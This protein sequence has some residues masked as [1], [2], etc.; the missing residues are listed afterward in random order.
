METKIQLLNANDIDKLNELVSI[1]ERVFEMENFKRPTRKHFEQVLYQDNFIA[2]IAMIDGRVVGGLTLYILHQYYS[3]KPL[4]YL[5]D[6]AV[7]PEYQRIGIGKKL[8]EFIVD[9]GKRQ[10]FDE[11][12]VQADKAD[13]H[14]LD[15]YRSTKPGRE[16]EVIQFSYL[17]K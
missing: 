9:Y 2:V 11:L 16:D 14:A 17:L 15:F 13:H 1:F 8:M 12:Y 7:L 10:G 5:Y 6:L 3:E 4:A